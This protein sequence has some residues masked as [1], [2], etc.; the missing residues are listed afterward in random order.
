MNKPRT[1][2][3]ESD[4]IRSPRRVVS[5]PHHLGEDVG[6][7]LR[8]KRERRLAEQ[9][10]PQVPRVPP[11][12]SV[13]SAPQLRPLSRLPT[14]NMPQEVTRNGSTRALRSTFYNHDDEHKRTFLQQC[15]LIEKLIGNGS[16]GEVFACK[17]RQTGKKYAIKVSI[18]LV[19]GKLKYKEAMSHMKIPPHP[20]L[21]EFFRA[22]D[23]HER[24]YIQTELCEKS[25]QEYCYN[26]TLTNNGAWIFFVDLLRATHH[27]HTNN[28]IHDD[29]KPENIFLTKDLKCKLGDFGLTFDC[30][31]PIHLKVADEGDSKYLATEVLNSRPTKES[32]M[33]SLGVTIFEVRTDADLPGRGPTWHDIRNGRIP[34]RF[35]EGVCPELTKMIQALLSRD[36][37]KRPTAQDLM[38]N[39]FVQEK[40]RI[41]DKGIIGVEMIEHYKTELQEHP[42]SPT[43]EVPT[44]P[45]KTKTPEEHS[46]DVYANS[47]ISRA[48]SNYFAE[49]EK[50]EKRSIRYGDQEG[51]PKIGMLN[52]DLPFSS[53]E[54]TDEEKDA[55]GSSSDKKEQIDGA[56]RNL[57]LAP[58]ANIDPSPPAISEQERY[59]RYQRML[60]NEMLRDDSDLNDHVVERPIN[61]APPSR[62]RDRSRPVARIK[63]DWDILNN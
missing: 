44:T 61:S 14:D 35:Y 4:D 33:F 55:A 36:P 56:V 45:Q 17:C 43:P 42:R 41:R 21:L 50:L 57:V 5:T 10:T 28:M 2:V 38:D 46:A 32:D 13:K 63:L 59:E 48:I 20:N 37:M 9:L 60:E 1:V 23:Q 8:T 12:K 24:L 6:V 25:L 58:Q 54:E 53:E 26:G 62:L 16:F 7:P 49:Q 52:F 34:P 39:S 30:S 29:I 19:R 15:F 40:M 51:A 22:W 3:A 27:L 18:K 31:D 11:N 47:S